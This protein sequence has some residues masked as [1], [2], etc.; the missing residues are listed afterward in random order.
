MRH[1]IV[2]TAVLFAVGVQTDAAWASKRLS[3]SYTKAQVKKDCDA[4]GGT[5][6]EGNGGSYGCDAPNGNSVVCGGS[7]CYG[8]C[9]WK[10]PDCAF[11]SNGVVGFL[12]QRPRYAG[13]K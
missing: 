1:L 13:K 7:T 9:G 3:G 6:G 4:A 10:N 12:H 5:Y 2:L 11:R 8:D